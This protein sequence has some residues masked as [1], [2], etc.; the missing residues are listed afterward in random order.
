MTRS[1]EA[2]D[3]SPL[4]NGS[5]VHEMQGESESALVFV[6]CGQNR[7]E[8]VRTAKEIADRL[9]GLGFRA[10]VAREEHTATGVK[11]AIF[12]QLSSADYYLFVDFSR[13]SLD[14]DPKVHRGSLYSNQELAVASFL[15]LP[16]LPFQQAGVA[17]EGHLD[18][19]LANAIKFSAP[20]E[21]PRLVETEVRRLVAAGSWG[22]HLRRK[23]T[24]VRL[25]DEESP[26]A[27]IE[28]G[29]WGPDGLKPTKKEA[30]WL[31]VE[32][33][34]LW[35][36]VAT[37][38]HA[39]LESWQELPAGETVRPDLVELKWGGVKSAR[40]TI[41]PGA[42]RVLDIAFY[43]SEDPSIVT[44]S[45]NLFLIDS[46]RVADE[47]KLPGYGDYRLDL[48]VYCREFGPFRRSLILSARPYPAGVRLQGE[49]PQLSRP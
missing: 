1:T 32:V 8:E 17:R 40:I 45:A 23:L 37:D 14:G 7:P 12:R 4:P 20:S 18:S 41:P 48:A 42:S 13:E 33:R 44:L 9:E 22:P 34:N 19:I 26:P 36:S 15:N 30:R 47:F 16:I 49:N 29:E 43:L 39:Y 35:H 25:G 24:V 3:Q 38:C 11:E 46:T 5:V 21:V 10:Y 31:Q 28:V 27:W 6:S 2:A